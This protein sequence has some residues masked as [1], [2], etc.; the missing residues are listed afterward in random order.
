MQEQISTFLEINNTPETSSLI[1]WDALKAFL[2]GQ[3]ISYS[4]NMKKKASRERL[5]LAKQIK[6]I[7]LQYAQVKDPDLYKKRLELQAKLN[8]LSTHSAERQLLRSK[9]RFY[10]HG[11]KAGKILA[12]QLKETQTMRHHK[13]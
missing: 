8:L 12:N 9:S 5:E 1:V 6:E 10:M 3:I 11:D 2:R 7:D 4:A 13:N